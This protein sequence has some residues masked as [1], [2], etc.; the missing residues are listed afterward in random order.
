MINYIDWP[1]I[2]KERLWINFVVLILTVI[3]LYFYGEDVNKFIVKMS[4]KME[5]LTKK[6]KSKK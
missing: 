5:N 1:A 4:S 6:D 2:I 3:F